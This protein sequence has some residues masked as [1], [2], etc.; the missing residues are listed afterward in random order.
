[1]PRIS[2]TIEIV[3]LFHPVTGEIVTEMLSSCM[4]GYDSI[5]LWRGRKT[6]RFFLYN[7]VDPRPAVDQ[8]LA[9]RRVTANV[10][11]PTKPLERLTLVGRV[12]H[13]KW[14]SHG[15]DYVELSRAKLKLRRVLI[16]E[17]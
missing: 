15:S 3:T 6:G 12:Y 7:L 8:K 16:D 2:A 5:E 9:W 14:H 11:S 4:K 10:I 13:S 17:V 1:M